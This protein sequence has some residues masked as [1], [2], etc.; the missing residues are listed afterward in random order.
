[1]CS[2]PSATISDTNVNMASSS[3]PKTDIDVLLTQ[4]KSDSSLVEMTQSPSESPKAAV[5]KNR[6]S[7]CK[8]KVGLTGKSVVCQACIDFVQDLTV[9]AGES[10]AR[11]TVIRTLTRVLSTTRRTVGDSLF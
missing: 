3:A 10:S 9:V 8:R 4:H 2:S 11:N 5:P 1:L 7:T 6:C